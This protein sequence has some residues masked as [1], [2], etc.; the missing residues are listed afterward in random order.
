MMNT[1]GTALSEYA[2]ITAFIAISVIASVGAFADQTLDVFDS[3]TWVVKRERLVNTGYVS[4]FSDQKVIGIA[5][6]YE[7]TITFMFEE[8]GYRN[9]LGMYKFDED[10]VIHDVRII[11]ANASAQ[12]SGGDLTPGESSVT[13]PLRERD[14]IGFF[15]A[16]NAYSRNRSEYLLEGDYALLDEEGKPATLFSEDLLTL[17]HEDPDTGQYRAIRTQYA[18]NLFYSHADPGEDYRPNVDG[19]PHTVG[20]V[21]QDSGIVTLGFEDLLSGGDNDYDDIVLEFDVGRSNAAVLDP[22]ISYDYDGYED[23]ARRLKL[24]EE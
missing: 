19:Y 23:W 1:K 20:W 2:T 3:S 17:W 4:S 18:N 9:A 24:W 12:G 13:V 5:E 10:G 15:V 11:F 21:D 7:G 16:S 6:D 22:N 14:Q 8:A